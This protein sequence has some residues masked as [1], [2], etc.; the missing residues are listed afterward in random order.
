MYFICLPT[1]FSVFL[2]PVP[3]RISFVKQEDIETWSNHLSLR[4]LTRMKTSAYSSMAA[5][6]F[7]ANLLIGYMVLVR[8]FQ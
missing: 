1:S 3:C 7:C 6:I 8:N 2:L 4:F 5:W